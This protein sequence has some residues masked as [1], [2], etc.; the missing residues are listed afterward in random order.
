MV[1]L[2]EQLAS[3][4]SAKRFVHP[5]S[6]LAL[7]AQLAAALV[8]DFREFRDAA[9]DPVL[10]A[11]AELPEMQSYRTDT[12]ALA[13]SALDLA[14]DA[15]A[16]WPSA[17]AWADF[18]SMRAGSAERPKA[19]PGL[20]WRKADFAHRW[21]WTTTTGAENL[22]AIRA[23]GVK[24]ANLESAGAPPELC[25]RREG[26]SRPLGLAAALFDLGRTLHALLTT[27]KQMESVDIAGPELTITYAPMT[28]RLS[29]APHSPGRFV[30]TAT[31]PP[32][33]LTGVIRTAWIAQ[34]KELDASLF[35]TRTGLPSSIDVLT[36]AHVV[37]P[38]STRRCSHRCAACSRGAAPA[39]DAEAVSLSGARAEP[40][41]DLAHIAA[42]DIKSGPGNFLVSPASLVTALTCQAD[43]QERERF[44]LL[45]IFEH[46]FMAPAAAILGFSDR[47]A[48]LGAVCR[49][50]GPDG[51]AD[52]EWCPALTR[53]RKERRPAKHQAATHRSPRRQ[54]A[55]PTPT[56]SPDAPGSLANPARDDNPWTATFDPAAR[57]PWELDDRAAAIPPA[58][59]HLGRPVRAAKRSHAEASHSDAC[60][61]SSRSWGK[62]DTPAKR[63]PRQPSCQIFTSESPAAAATNPVLAE[64]TALLTDEAQSHEGD[65]GLE[66][67]EASESHGSFDTYESDDGDF[68]SGLPCLEHWDEKAQPC[69]GGRSGAGTRAGPWLAH[70]SAEAQGGYTLDARCDPGGRT[71]SRF[72]PQLRM[73]SS[74]A[75]TQMAV[76]ALAATTTT[77]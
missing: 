15:E 8:D 1:T 13:S 30:P 40:A 14:G 41:R 52:H 27:A 21:A 54:E 32:V 72:P 10:Q 63:A 24:V 6:A 31:W 75:Q 36:L 17:Q 49:R 70:E 77:A 61:A 71:A 20:R 2:A 74:A 5:C 64:L 60:V 44:G 73:P 16:A 35:Q 22:C 46:P 25:V 55:V 28:S 48:M 59:A 3:I 45:G 33:A 50:L 34:M 69:L 7:F 68:E 39:G 76:S 11:A 12:I 62:A 57:M 58:C 65:G 47:T 56:A 42:V 9:E 18:V 26:C 29:R 53:A 19:F 67:D 43:P 23:E 4:K 37:S 51:G 66:S 38:A